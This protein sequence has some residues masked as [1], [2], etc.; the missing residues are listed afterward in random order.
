MQL[1]SSPTKLSITVRMEIHPFPGWV[2]IEPYTESQTIAGIELPDSG[3]EELTRGKVLEVGGVGLTQSGSAIDVPRGLKEGVV[4]AYKKY[5]D[6]P[7]EVEGVEYK[8]VHLENIMCH[9]NG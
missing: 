4:V 8:L 6:H 1:L 3:K 9:I 7:L 5:A 2:L